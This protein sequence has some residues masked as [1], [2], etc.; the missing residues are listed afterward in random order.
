MGGK[1]MKA[2]EA[3]TE[4]LSRIREQPVPRGVAEVKRQALD[5]V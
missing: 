4:I 5:Y 3:R 1:G 2:V